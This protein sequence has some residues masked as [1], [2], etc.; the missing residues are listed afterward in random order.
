MLRNQGF[1]LSSGWALTNLD[2][3]FLVETIENGV[4]I[5]KIILALAGL[6]PAE[7]KLLLRAE[8]CVMGGGL[9]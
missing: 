4:S 2:H 5:A 3:R 8:W 7:L 9:W 1:T 6:R